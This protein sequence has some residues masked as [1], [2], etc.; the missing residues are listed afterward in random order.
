MSIAFWFALAAAVL[1]LAG[2]IVGELA[3]NPDA[4]P[5]VTFAGWLSLGLV[6]VVTA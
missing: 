4:G 5:V 6:V 1:V 2:W 3:D